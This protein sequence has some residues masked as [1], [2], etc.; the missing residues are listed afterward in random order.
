[1]VRSLG[2]RM[3][4]SDDVD[5]CADVRCTV[6][7]QGRVC[8]VLMGAADVGFPGRLWCNETIFRLRVMCMNDV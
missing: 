2:L 8:V 6:G 7:G 3:M 1:M 5:V 4:L